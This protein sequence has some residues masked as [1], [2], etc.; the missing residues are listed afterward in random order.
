VTTMLDDVTTLAPARPSVPPQ[1]LLPA[2][3]SGLD[4]LL[5]DDDPHWLDLMRRN[6][7]PAGASL[8]TFTDA[9]AALAAAREVRPDVFICDLEMPG[10]NGF[11]LV[12]ELRADSR[13]SLVPV[14]VL[15]GHRD[16]GSRTASFASGADCYLSKSSPSEELIAAAAALGGHGRMLRDVESS[17][18]VLI[19]L[20]RMVDLHCLE[21]LGHME[22]C[23]RLARGFG[24][25]LGLDERSLRALAHAGY[26]H[27][28]GKIG[29]PW[30]VLNKRGPLTD[31]ERQHIQRHPVIGVT[32][33]EPLR[34]LADVL[35]IIR[36][37][38]ERWDG[39]GYPDGLAGV[40]IPLL[41]RVFQIADIY[42]ALVSRRCYKEPMAPAAALAILRDE[43]ARGWRDPLLVQTFARAIETGQLRGA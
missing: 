19:A 14:M 13:L 41:A 12:R 36:H 8:R 22:R 21:T 15:S 42:E 39:G 43:A 3:L 37:H 34:S 31:D 2:E 16:E 7:Q 29:V 18:A 24:E 17:E 6:L 28:V 5:V 38:H 10:R 40:E 1:A 4:M 23:A 35:P 11:D 33:C 30:D 25:L 26:L 32:I 9:T 27:D 20:A